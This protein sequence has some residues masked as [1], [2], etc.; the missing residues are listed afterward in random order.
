MTRERPALESYERPTG[1]SE[2]ELLRGYGIREEEGPEGCR[3]AGCPCLDVLEEL[4]K[5]EA[6]SDPAD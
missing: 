1:L 2:A 5:L 4:E 3:I 6:P